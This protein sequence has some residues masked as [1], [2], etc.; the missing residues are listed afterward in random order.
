MNKKENGTIGFCDPF[1][2]N[3]H[4]TQGVTTSQKRKLDRAQEMVIY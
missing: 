4:F 1:E 2:G 3:R